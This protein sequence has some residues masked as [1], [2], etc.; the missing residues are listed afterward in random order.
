MQRRFTTSVLALKRRH[1]ISNHLLTTG[2][3]STIVKLQ[4][5]DTFIPMG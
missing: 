2:M 5:C 1:L 3:V 4:S